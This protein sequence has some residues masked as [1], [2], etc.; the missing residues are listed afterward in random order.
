MAALYPSG[1]ISLRW[2]FAPRASKWK[3]WWRYF[4][5]FLFPF[6]LMRFYI[7]SIRTR[8]PLFLTLIWNMWFKPFNFLFTEKRKKWMNAVV[9]CTQC[10]IDSFKCEVRCYFQLLPSEVNHRPNIRFGI[11]FRDTF[12][13]SRICQW[14]FKANLLT[15][16]WQNA[17]FVG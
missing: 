2:F 1:H 9:I 15:L 4:I 16:R 3:A 7:S 6:L 13:A 8:T 14:S 10:L 17:S 11:R 5:W 12:F